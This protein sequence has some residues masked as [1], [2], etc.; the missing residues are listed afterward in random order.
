MI[1]VYGY[2]IQVWNKFQ[3]NFLKII[4]PKYI[5]NKNSIIL[6]GKALKSSQPQKSLY[7]ILNICGIYSYNF[8]FGKTFF[9][10]SPEV[11]NLNLL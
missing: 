6:K 5:A 8:I 1:K 4:Q 10:S 11:A 3:I 9:L 7:E 2:K